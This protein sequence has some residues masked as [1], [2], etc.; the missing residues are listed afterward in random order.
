MDTCQ[1]TVAVLPCL[2]KLP[3]KRLKMFRSSKE[4]ARSC[5]LAE[6][7]WRRQLLAFDAVSNASDASAAV[8]SSRPGPKQGTGSDV[9]AVA[10]AGKAGRIVLLTAGQLLNDTGAY[11]VFGEKRVR[12]AAGFEIAYDYY[13]KSDDP[14][15]ENKNSKGIT[16]RSMPLIMATSFL[17]IL[18]VCI[19]VCVSGI[20]WERTR[21]LVASRAASTH[22]T[23]ME[24]SHHNA[25]AGDSN[26]PSY[27]NDKYMI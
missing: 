5:K 19:A 11:R 26:I 8:S 27:S 14:P 3:N 15:H 7:A 20:C 6:L 22:V 10:S 21:R 25:A 17:V 18:I 9:L 1:Q 12:K 13:F 2:A 24:V 4:G 16:K 23:S